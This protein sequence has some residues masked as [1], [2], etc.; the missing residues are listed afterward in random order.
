MTV[1]EAYAYLLDWQ[2]A[3]L[4]NGDTPMSDAVQSLSFAISALNT[5]DMSDPISR[6][7]LLNVLS[8]FNDTVNGNEHFLYGIETAREIIRDAPS[9]LAEMKIES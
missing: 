9:V 4:Q 8:H 6:S 7:Y 1:K 3:L 5:I 2:M